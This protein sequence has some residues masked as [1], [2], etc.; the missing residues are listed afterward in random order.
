M[1]R[2]APAPLNL[3]LESGSDS[4]A[5]GGSAAE[6]VLDAELAGRGESHDA[7]SMMMNSMVRMVQAGQS[8]QSR[9]KDS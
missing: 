9:W 6:Q 2:S 8:S 4:H 3:A 7:L 5:A 1:K